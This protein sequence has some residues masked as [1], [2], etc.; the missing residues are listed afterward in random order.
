[1]WSLFV[2]CHFVTGNYFFACTHFRRRNWLD[3]HRTLLQI[4]CAEEALLHTGSTGARIIY[5]EEDP[6][7]HFETS[8]LRN[9]YD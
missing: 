6:V 5:I 9:T 4:C 8:L 7:L 3:P 1:M 2:K